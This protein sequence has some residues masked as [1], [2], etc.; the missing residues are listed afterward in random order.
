MDNILSIYRTNFQGLPF[1]SY[2]PDITDLYI[3]HYN[4]MKIYSEEYS[5][6]IYFCNYD[7]L[8]TCPSEE[9][10]KLINWLGWDWSEKYLAPHTNKRSVFTASSEQVRNPI[11]TKS[12]SG[13]K[14]YR[15]LLEQASSYISENEDLKRH[16]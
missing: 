15:D 16:L 14:K 12:L 4:L 5:D 8:V 2:L 11:N 9:I 6:L 3:D 10:K 13:W 7:E 1:S